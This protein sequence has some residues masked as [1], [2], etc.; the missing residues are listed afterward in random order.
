VKVRTQL[1]GFVLLNLKPHQTPVMPLA[2][3]LFRLESQ[4]CAFLAFQAV[5]AAVGMAAAVVAAAV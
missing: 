2:N 5:A 1:Q 4:A 3:L